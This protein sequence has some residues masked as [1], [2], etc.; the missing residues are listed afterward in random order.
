MVYKNRYYKRSRIAEKT[1]RRIV[2]YFALGF[3]ASDTAR[4]TGISVRS[5]NSIYIKMIC[6]QWRVQV[7]WESWVVIVPDEV[8]GDQ[9]VVV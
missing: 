3:S 7:L 5:I 6:P 8:S 1:F 4:L 9:T 2:R